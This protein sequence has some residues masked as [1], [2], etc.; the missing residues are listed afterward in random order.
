MAYSGVTG[1]L[2]TSISG[3]TGSGIDLTMHYDEDGRLHDW[4][5]VGGS[6]SAVFEYDDADRLR[7]ASY[8]DGDVS[9]G[10]P[11]LAR[12]S[13][14]Y[15]LGGLRDAHGDGVPGDTSDDTFAYDAAGRLTSATHEHTSNDDEAYSYDR[16]GNRRIDGV[17]SQFVYDDANQLREDPRYTYAYDANGSRQSRTARVGG[18]RTEYRYDSEN[19]LIRVTLPSSDNVHF[20][21]DPLGRLVEKIDESPLGEIRRYL[22]DG[23]EV[24]AEF[25]AAGSMVRRYVTT[26]G[27]DMLLGVISGGDH[28]I[29]GTDSLG[30]VIGFIHAGGGAAGSYQYQA[31]G[32]IANEDGGIENERTFAGREY[33][34]S[35]DLY[36]FR[37][38]FYDPNTGQFLQRDPLVYKAATMPYAYA[39]NNPTNYRDPYGLNEGEFAAFA[40]LF[41]KRVVEP[42]VQRGVGDAFAQ[43]P[44]IPHHINSS[45]VPLPSVGNWFRAGVGQYYQWKDVIEVFGAEDPFEA[46]INWYDSQ[47]WNPVRGAMLES[48]LTMGGTMPRH[49]SR[50]APTCVSSGD[51]GRLMQPNLHNSK[52]ARRRHDSYVQQYGTRPLHR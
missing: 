4:R 33:E 44:N 13:W 9:G 27:V 42:L 49:E 2:P 12:L 29:A 14:G 8:Y 45:I 37:A 26:D 38:R 50:I 21:Y 5:Q 36:H 23:D 6:S 41:N 34:R 32:A 19:R 16:A 30:T 24:L 20:A 28:Y 18:A 35:T 47:P 3:G 43:I 51:R 1:W 25:D 22:Y 10:D 46:G 48:F 11:L 52:E 15:T 7:V 31:F 39:G 17:E 40:G